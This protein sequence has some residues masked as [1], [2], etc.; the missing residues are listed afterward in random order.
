MIRCH[1]LPVTKRKVNLPWLS[2]DLSVLSVAPMEIFASKI[3]ALINRSAPRDLYD[4]HNLLEFGLFDESEQFNHVVVG[5]FAAGV[6]HAFADDAQDEG[7]FAVFER[8]GNP[9]FGIARCEVVDGFGPVAGTNP[10]DEGK[11][12]YPDVVFSVMAGV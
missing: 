10:R 5:A 2:E 3:V 9:F 11:F 6:V 4:I 8:A 12:S 7:V 1:I